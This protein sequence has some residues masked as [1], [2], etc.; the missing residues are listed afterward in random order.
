MDYSI[1]KIRFLSSFAFIL[2]F[3][4]FLTIGN[5]YLWLL[6]FIL[7]SIFIY[8]IYYNFINYKNKFFLYIYV[9]ISFIFLQL[10]LFYY[11]QIVDF[12]IIIL[13]ITIFDTSSY[14]LGSLIGQRKI[15]SISPNK[16]YEGLFSGII[17]TIIFMIIFNYYFTNFYFYSF[18]L[19][20]LLI[21]LLSFLGDIIESY[22]KRL[23]N[24]KNSSKLIPGHGGF[25]DRFDS[26]IFVTYGMFFY[27]F[28]II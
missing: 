21:I 28:L 3:L 14:F 17:F 18:C 2:L 15:L 13:T 9:L 11:F 20:I 10:Y 24:I 6:F 5:N 7:Y 19:I 12:I 27:K 23:S 22:F 8:E 25:L 16:T 4:F 26:F 1:L